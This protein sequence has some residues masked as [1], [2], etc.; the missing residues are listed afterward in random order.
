MPGGKQGEAGKGGGSTDWLLNPKNVVL[1]SW[2]RESFLKVLS[3]STCSFLFIFCSCCIYYESLNSVC[4][5]F[6]IIYRKCSSLIT[7]TIT[8]LLSLAFLLDTFC[9]SY[10]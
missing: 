5:S 9:N 6:L 2:T 3:F 7:T 1:C 4:L 8:T 10:T